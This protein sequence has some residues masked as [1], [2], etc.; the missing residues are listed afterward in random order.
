VSNEQKNQLPTRV[1][2]EDLPSMT[3]GLTRYLAEIRK[4]PMLEPDEEYMLAKR[5]QE[6]ED[7]KAAERLVGAHL[8]LVAKIANGY[9]GYGLPVIDLIAEGN[10]GLMQALRK[11]DPE[12]GFRFSTYAMWWIRA[13]IQEYIL[14]S[15]SLVK[16]G[17]TAAQKKLFFNLRRLKGKMQELDEPIISAQT[18]KDI[19]LELNVSEDEV[20]D[21]SRRIS[22]PDQSLNVPLKAEGLEEWQD[23]L[24]DD[25]S[26]HEMK[27]MERDESKR[28]NSLLETAL[29]SLNERERRIIQERR[30]KEPS[31]T[32]EALS[33]SLGISRERVR[34]IEHR[35]F[36]K[37][38]KAVKTAAI[39]N[40]M[41][42]S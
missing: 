9:R 18:I 17:T 22:G 30:L 23:W 33:E 16:I 7:P 38:Q 27:F 4:F 26:T 13:N 24:V 37:L 11:F 29:Q 2:G 15:W 31:T 20:V 42:E 32:L 34:Q 6:H 28:K 41:L 40:R 12:K 19:A 36:E 10:V 8:R 1:K 5:W 21:M 35:A 25:E 39:Q 3:D 14:H